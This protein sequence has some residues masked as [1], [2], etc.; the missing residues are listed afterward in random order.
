MTEWIP[1]EEGEYWVEQ[2]YLVSA[3]K[4]AIA[5]DDPMIEI[6]K[7]P[8]GRRYLKGQ[9]MVYNLLVVELLENHESLDILLD[10]GGDFKYILEAP[11]ISSG[12]LFVPDVKS[13]LQFAPQQ[14]WCQISVDAFAEEVRKL[15]RIDS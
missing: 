7:N 1:F 2:A 12:K 11:Q 5:L 3:D 9:G 8:R 6:G 13:T 10:L 15:N 4:S 14:P